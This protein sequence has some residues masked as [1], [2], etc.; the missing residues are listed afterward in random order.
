MT[1]YDLIFIGVVLFL[2]SVLQGAV[3]FAYTLFALPLLIWHGISLS[4]SVALVSIST[5]IQ[6]MVATFQLRIDVR[7]REV[8]PASLIRFVTLPIGIGL[9]VLIDA[10]DQTQV[11]QI[12]GTIIL[13]VLLAQIFLRI[14]PK[15]HLHPGWTLLTFSISGV[16]QG[17]AT[18]GGPPVILWL[19]AQHRTNRETRA[20]LMALFMIG[21]PVQLTMLYYSAAQDLSV[22]MLTGLAFA[23]VVIIGSS[24]GV[25]LGNRMSKE[26]LR[27]IA[28]GILFITA[29]GSIVSP[30]F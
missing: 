2:G 12:L 9:L 19:M 3:G 18:M 5:F 17:I 25:S 29:I 23:P 13:T 30:F 10:L 1:P 16:M 14:E 20:F 28:F 8:I 24:L 27:T 22:A 4:E 11:K 15:E 7:W 26:L 21:A 6:V